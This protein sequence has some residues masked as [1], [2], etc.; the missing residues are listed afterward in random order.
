MAKVLAVDDDPQVLTVLDRAL[1]QAGYE[2]VVARTGTDGLAAAAATRPS[3]VLVDLRLPD[4]DG[5]EVVRRLRTWTRIPIVLLSGAGSVRT[6]V[7]ALDAGADD[8]VDKPFSMDELRARVGAQLRRSSVTDATGD[9]HAVTVGDLEI[10]LA[11]R[12]VTVAGRT[13]RLTPTQWRLLEV[14]VAHPGELLTYRTII[15]AVWDDRH[16]DE[17]RDALRVHL[18]Q[19][20]TKLGDDASEPRYI[21]TEAGLGCRWLPGPP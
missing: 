4:I 21:A 7:R 9:G 20:R 11:S 12:K 5:I 3:L 18:R 17:T 6:R 19:L 14:L 15:A 1:S 2:V 8:F 10:D 13:V 16:G